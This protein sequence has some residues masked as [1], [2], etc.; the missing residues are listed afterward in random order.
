M[1]S[2]GTGRHHHPAMRADRTLERGSGDRRKGAD[3]RPGN[4]GSG[5]RHARGSLQTA[6]ARR[7]GKALSQPRRRAAPDYAGPAR[8]SVRFNTSFSFSRRF[9]KRAPPVKHL[10][11]TLRPTPYGRDN[12]W[13][14]GGEPDKPG[15]TRGLRA[16]HKLGNHD[17][18]RHDPS[19]SKL[20][21]LPTADAAGGDG[22]Q[23][24]LP[25]RASA[26][27]LRVRLRRDHDPGVAPAH[28]R[29]PQ[30]WAADG[31]RP[32]SC[33][34]GA[35]AAAGAAARAPDGAFEGLKR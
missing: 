21:S 20:C 27:A 14:S 4:G 22:I 16:P 9:S 23:P 18:V 10:T 25:V 1:P 31:C 29:V 2:D 15:R 11:G 33:R 17:G 26:R 30:P 32:P 7:A 8:T 34:I 35:L 13:L 5:P 6:G 19:A 12:R 24:D 3:G 28:L